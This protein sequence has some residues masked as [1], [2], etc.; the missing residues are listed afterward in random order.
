MNLS[1]SQ[2]GMF[3]PVASLEKHQ[4]EMKMSKFHAKL[5]CLGQKMDE[6][7]LL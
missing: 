6:I 4:E 1:G 2:K 7:H 3:A 5:L